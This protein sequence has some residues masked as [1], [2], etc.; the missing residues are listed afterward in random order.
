MSVQ[1][2]YVKLLGEGPDVWVPVQA[3]R[4]GDGRFRVLGSMPDDVEWE[5]VPGDVIYGQFK[6]FA[7]GSE[8]WVA[9]SISD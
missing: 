7:D 8:G 9:V 6:A 5:F 2:I 3:Q 4:L 1:A